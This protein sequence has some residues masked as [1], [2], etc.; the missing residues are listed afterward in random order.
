MRVG[1]VFSVCSNFSYGLYATPHLPHVNDKLSFI[2]ADTLD[3]TLPTLL[4]AKVLYMNWFR[5][6]GI[7]FKASRQLNDYLS[8]FL[9]TSSKTKFT[10]HVGERSMSAIIGVYRNILSVRVLLFR[11]YFVVI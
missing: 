7:I 5:R 1:K 2:P 3:F 6:Q 10:I 4:L 8:G 9:A 11:S